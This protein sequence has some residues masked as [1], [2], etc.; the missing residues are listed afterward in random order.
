M[1]SDSLAASSAVVE[2]P[3]YQVAI[4]IVSLDTDLEQI[5]EEASTTAVV[6]DCSFTWAALAVGNSDIIIV[7]T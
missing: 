5:A 6:E 2:A 7:A 1:Q 3:Y 4:T